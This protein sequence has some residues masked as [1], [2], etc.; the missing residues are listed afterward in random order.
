MLSRLLQIT[1]GKEPL[2]SQL[3][4]WSSTLPRR[5]SSN[6]NAAIN[7]YPTPA[8]K[9]IVEFEQEFLAGYLK[10]HYKEA[11]QILSK[12]T[13][14]ISSMVEYLE[15]Y[16]STGALALMAE[17]SMLECLYNIRPHL[18][19]SSRLPAKAKMAIVV[20]PQP[21]C[22]SG[23]KIPAYLIDSPERENKLLEHI[24]SSHRDHLRIGDLGSPV[25][26][27]FVKPG[28]LPPFYLVPRHTLLHM[29]PW[30]KNPQW[31]RKIKN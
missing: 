23:Y 31:G 18:I 7:L 2:L 19:Q 29:T 4:M 11:Y 13:L 27:T 9:D 8:V 22:I 20:N 10:Q 24:P 14:S 12:S 1:Q 16:D 17:A 5:L 21:P 15:R 3:G 30:I 28:S 25:N 26:C 6:N